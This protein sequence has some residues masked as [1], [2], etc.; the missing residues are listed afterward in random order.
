MKLSRQKLAPFFVF[1]VAA[2]LALPATSKLNLTL[3]SAYA[4][5][6]S[7]S[8]VKSTP[9]QVTPQAP[10]VGIAAPTNDNCASAVA[11][12][13]CPFTDTKS[14]VGATTETGEPAPC[15][16]IAA[17]MWYSY[18]NSRPNPVSV[19][20][21]TCTSSP[22]DTVLAAY[23]VTGAACAFAGFVN[24]ACNDDFCGDGF[25]SSIQFTADPG[26]NYKIQVGG[27]AGSTGTITTNID[28]VEQLC[29]SVVI[30][31]T[32]GSGAPGF[33]GVQFSGD[34]TGRLNRNGI[35]SSC[36]APKTCLIFDP[37]G[38]RKF[39]AYQITNQSGQAAC[40]TI[41][42]TETAGQT[43]NLQSN[44]YLNTY[45][46]SSICT[47]YLG[48]PGLSTGS[49]PTPTNFSVTVPA[50]GT[51]IVVVHT[52]NPGEV[53]CTYT[54]TVA[55]NL[56]VQFDYCVQ[57]DN[58]P[59][60]FVQISSTTGKYK[61][62][63][64]GKGL[65]LEGTGSVSTYFCKTELFDMGPDPKRPDRFVDVLVNTCTKVGD[66]NIQFG[67]NSITLHDSN[68]TNNTCACPTQ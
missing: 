38:L 52:T 57:D 61:Y 49:P 5:D 18:T 2:L 23:K 59:K 25:Q 7:Q 51:L 30:N 37:A 3:V 58:N 24:V 11:V 68:I 20:A 16:S 22:T 46:P 35:A 45:T 26:A 17:T 42:L 48:D 54:V 6:Q 4:Q 12:T 41:N 14:N 10:N 50:G 43:C 27:F 63:D 19:S 21:T 39:D 28:C 8:D 34:Q 56:C 53:G 62:Q 66:A 40:A 65:T 9:K 67:G 29:P 64:C 31:G 1:L 15:G 36:A 47:G 44:A 32:L 33:T 60:R 55:G 13:S